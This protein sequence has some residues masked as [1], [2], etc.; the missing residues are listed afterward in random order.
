MGLLLIG[1]FSLSYA[2]VFALAVVT[3]AHQPA[4]YKDKFD[5]RINMGNRVALIKARP[6]LTEAHIPV[7]LDVRS[8][9]ITH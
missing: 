9:H 1:L 6:S 8:Y 2:G 7:D 4:F 3:V 5:L